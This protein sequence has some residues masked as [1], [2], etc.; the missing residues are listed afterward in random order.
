[1]FASRLD[2]DHAIVVT[3]QPGTSSNR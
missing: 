2:A 3:A 1:L